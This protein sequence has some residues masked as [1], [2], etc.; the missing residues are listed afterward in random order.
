MSNTETVLVLEDEALIALDLAQSLEEMGFEAV[1]AGTVVDA[2]LLIQAR[3][4]DF[5]ILD[6]RVGDR[7]TGEVAE[8][9][10][11]KQ[12]PFALC[13][14]SEVDLAQRV[15]QGV[16]LIPKPFTQDVLREALQSVRN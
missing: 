7:D 2:L 9:L 14:G 13:S 10:R 11:E 6:Y 12:I 3:S 8:L 16:A 15:F 1:V 4:I 5:A